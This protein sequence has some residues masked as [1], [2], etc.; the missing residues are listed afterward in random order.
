M[1]PDGGPSDVWRWMLRGF[2]SAVVVVVALGALAVWLWLRPLREGYTQAA[3]LWLGCALFVGVTALVWWP[4]HHG[5][6]ARR[7]HHRHAGVVLV[8]L[9]AVS[10]LMAE[11][12]IAVAREDRRPPLREL[13]ATVVAGEPLRF[14]HEDNWA[15]QPRFEGGLGNSD[16]SVCRTFAVAGDPAPVA[17]RVGA[18][19]ATAGVDVGEGAH[20]VGDATPRYAEVRVDGAAGDRLVVCVDEVDPDNR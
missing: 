19:L 8:G 11:L 15:Y 6:E 10:A 1:A 16:W 2:V 20:V 5:E 14:E 9:L 3:L 7:G 17:G 4:T 13:I 18:A 12:G